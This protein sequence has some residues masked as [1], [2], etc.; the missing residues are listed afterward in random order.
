MSTLSL[1]SHIVDSL[2][3]RFC[4]VRKSITLLWEFKSDFSPS[5]DALKMFVCMGS[6]HHVKPS[7]CRSPPEYKLFQLFCFL[8]YLWRCSILL[9][10]CKSLSGESRKGASFFWSIPIF[11]SV[12]V[13]ASLMSQTLNLCIFHDLVE[14][15]IHLLRCWV[16]K[17]RSLSSLACVSNSP[18]RSAARRHNSLLSSSSAFSSCTIRVSPFIQSEPHRVSWRMFSLWTQAARSSFPMEA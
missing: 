5:G 7:R 17:I 4:Q 16:I 10:L 8:S 11:F 1:N 15:S 18:Q 13:A 6:L 9:R 3:S 14:F 12:L 2:I